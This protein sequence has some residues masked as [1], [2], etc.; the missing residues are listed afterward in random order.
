MHA[1]LYLAPPSTE[2][3]RGHI[4]SGRLG[5][6][7]TPSSGNRVPEE[8][9]WA[10]DSGIFGN[11]Y[12]GDDAYMRWLEER[13][14]YA[15]RCL[16]ATAPDVVGN[17][18]ASV[19]RSYSFLKRIRDMGY[20]VALVAQDYAEFCPY[21]DWDDFDCLFIGGSTAWK[22]SPAAAVLARAAAAAGRW[23][24]VG[25][26]NS[27]KRDRYAA[28]AMDADSVDG[29]LLTNGPDVHLPSVLAW[30]W[31]LLLE[32]TL[33]LVDVQALT[34]DPYDGRYQLDWVPPVAAA[35]RGPAPEL[36]QLTLI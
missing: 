6:I 14:E 11:S 21:W 18:F 26:V 35:P 34:S 30:T 10:A 33:P 28:L 3:I 13:A 31:H 20:P 17:A 12:V 19:N 23:V 5:A 29:T 4:H 7:V 1:P 24:H 15:N 9:L 16:F 25:R 22:L 2:R 32:D 36:E 8:G 27:L